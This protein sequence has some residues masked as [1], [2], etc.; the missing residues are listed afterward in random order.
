MKKKE[1]IEQKVR[2]TLEVAHSMPN[3]QPK[4]GFEDRFWE[5]LHHERKGEERR[6]VSW[7]VAA[8]ILL[9]AL[10]AMVFFQLKT[11]NS[12]D[13]VQEIAYEFGL[14]PMEYYVDLNE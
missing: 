5:K 14:D 13:D 11:Q 10:N 4:A 12:Q 8:T 7:Q 9:V 1:H 6:F 3:A 2:E